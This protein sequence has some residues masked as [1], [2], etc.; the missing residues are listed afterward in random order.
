GNLTPIEY[1]YKMLAA[2]KKNTQL[3]AV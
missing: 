3:I 2:E 1:K